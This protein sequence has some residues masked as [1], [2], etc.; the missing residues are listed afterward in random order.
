MIE[1]EAAP[2]TPKPSWLIKL[3][4]ESWQAELIISGLAIYGT[5]QMPE[6][7]EWL[8]DWSLVNIDNRFHL[9]L[10]MFFVYLGIGA[11]ILILLFISH[12]VLRAV[13]IGFVGLN[14]VYP[15]GVS[16]HSE[17]YSTDFIQKFKADNP[18][19]NE[20]IGQLDRLCSLLFGLG[21]Q[22]CMIFLA[23]NIDLVI[24]GLLWYLADRFVSTEVGNVVAICFAASFVLYTLAFLISNFK[25]LRDRPLVRRWQYPVYK[26]FTQVMLHFFARPAAYVAMVFQT[27]QSM[28]RYAGMIILLMFVTMGFFFARFMDHRFLSFIRTDSLHEHYD[29]DDRLIPEQYASLRVDQRRLLSIELESEVVSGPFLRVFIPLLSGD[30]AAID[31]R[32]GP[33]RR[34]DSDERSVSIQWQDYYTD[35]YRQ[36]HRVYVNDSLYQN[37]DLI[38]YEHTNQGEEG[39]LVYLPNTDFRVGKNLLR[40]EKM[41]I[42]PEEVRRQMQAV[43]WYAEE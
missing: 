34:D 31:S 10:Y 24:V 42:E 17:L 18:D 19:G 2:P 4:E 21:A 29:H 36:I 1:P 15:N 25:S 14:S 28:K 37:L 20:W 12:F 43:F 33:F 27:N 6:L 3:E 32:C 26:I 7:V 11:Y 22:L 23:I 9:L 35:C 38:K 41:G 40:V 16:D 30:D 13:W 8:M 5:L 39:I